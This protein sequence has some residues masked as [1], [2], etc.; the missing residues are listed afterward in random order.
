M[1][2]LPQ[3]LLATVLLVSGT[4]QLAQADE[5]LNETEEREACSAF[6][7]AGMLECLQTK[8]KDSS[9]ALSAAEQTTARSITNWDED[10][11]YR[12]LAQ[13]LF[14]KSNQAFHRYLQT[15]CRLA[16]GLAGGSIGTALDMRRQACVIELN[17]RRIQQLR[18]MKHDL[19]MR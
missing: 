3:L 1:R 15:Q 19:E 5:V 7:E 9:V 16:A 14:Q 6:S 17:N 10:A 13:R 12:N 11:K 4:Y 8:A 2:P 18:L